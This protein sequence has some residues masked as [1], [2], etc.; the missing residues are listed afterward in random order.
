[1]EV[2]VTPL[3]YLSYCNTIIVSGQNDRNKGNVEP[4]MHA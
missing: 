4:Q 3:L 1:M 2:L